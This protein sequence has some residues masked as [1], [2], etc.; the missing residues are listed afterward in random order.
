[1]KGWI[2]LRAESRKSHIVGIRL[3]SLQYNELKKFCKNENI[4][5]SDYFRALVF[6]EK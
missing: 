2:E 6:K 1:M 3:T 4:T 5:F